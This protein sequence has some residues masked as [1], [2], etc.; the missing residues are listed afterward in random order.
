MDIIICHQSHGIGQRVDGR[1]MKITNK[2]ITLVPVFIALVFMISSIVSIITPQQTLALNCD[3]DFYSTNDILFYN[4]C[5]TNAS[6]CNPSPIGAI[7]TLRGANNGEKIYN[8]WVDAGLTAQQ[9]AGV[10]GSM[11]HEGGFSPFRQ[12]TSKSWPEGGW[13]I[14]QF[15]AGQRDAATKYVKEDI[16][17]SLFTNYYQNKYG[18]AVT[19]SSGFIPDGVPDTVNEK[20]LLAQLNYLLSYSKDYK[21]NSIRRG[22]M[23]EDYNKTIGSDV[24]LFDYLSSVETPGE[25]AVAWTYLYEAP[26]DHKNTGVE[27]AESAAQIYKLYT[28]AADGDESCA[29]ISSEKGF[30]IDQAKAFMETYKQIDN[31]DPN[32]DKKYLSSACHKLTDNCVTFVS[33]FVK[34]YT[35]IS[36]QGGNGGFVVNK[37][38]AADKTLKS[39]KVPAPFAIFSVHK[40][41]TMCGNIPCGHTGVVLGIED[42]KV[43][44]A[45]AAWCN[46]SFTGIHTYPLKDWTNTEYTYIYAADRLNQEIKGEFSGA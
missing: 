43:I 40:G 37:M 41:V 22:W 1:F 6:T 27:R 10:T 14:A 21:P 42:D 32:N 20:F 7:S 2:R 4:S 44:V 45:E 26:A 8:F 38:L 31:G 19:Q 17:D 12:E 46:P 11:K 3:E 28:G 39:G 18:G 30:S 13:G 15:T 5:A 25:A 34:K 29:S 36:F 24:I 9:A 16:G 33:Y 35:D 23:K